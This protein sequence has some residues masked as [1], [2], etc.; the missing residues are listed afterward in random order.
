MLSSATG[1]RDLVHP[2]DQARFD[3]TMARLLN[4][5]VEHTL[6]E[7]RLFARDGTCRWFEN[8]CVAL[9]D[10]SARL[11]E[12]EG[13]LTQIADDVPLDQEFARRAFPAQPPEPAS[14]LPLS[15]ICSALLLQPVPARRRLHCS[16]LN[17]E[18][19]EIL[20]RLR[21][22]ARRSGPPPV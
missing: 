8:R 3:M 4:R 20:T 12:I 7:F 15:N 14:G 21:Q 17:W 10:D 11:V 13:I 6:V 16:L 2:H 18:I 9:R 1:I 5:D 19:P 22:I